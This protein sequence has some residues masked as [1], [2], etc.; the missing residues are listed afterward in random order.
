MEN[1]TRARP[2]GIS[3]IAVILAIRVFLAAS[4]F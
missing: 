3:I 4:C 2:L 1:V